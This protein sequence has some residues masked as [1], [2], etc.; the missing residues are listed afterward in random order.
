MSASRR[1]LRRWFKSTSNRTFMVW[2][3]L[4]LAARALLDRGWPEV[5]LW[6]LPLLAWGYGQ[7]AWVGRLRTALGGGGPGLSNPPERLVTSGPYRWTRNPIYV[8]FF[9]VYGGI[10]VW[11]QSPWVLIL[12]LPLA[13]TIRYGVVARRTGA[14]SGVDRDRQV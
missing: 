6:G 10:G 7:Y 9:L 5:N 3:V 14:L 13:V 4:L 11:A 12:T 8:A 1:S 2:P